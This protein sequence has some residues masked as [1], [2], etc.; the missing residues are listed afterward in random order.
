MSVLL[1]YNADQV[2]FPFAVLSKKS[3][4]E[5]LLPTSC[6]TQHQHIPFIQFRILLLCFGLHQQRHQVFGCSHQL[7]ANVVCLLDWWCTVWIAFLLT[8][9]WQVSLNQNKDV[10]HKIQNDV[11]WL[12]HK[13]T[14]QQPNSRRCRQNKLYFYHQINR[15]VW[16]M[17]LKPLISVSDK[18]PRTVKSKLLKQ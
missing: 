9:R 2:L 18:N 7:V 14:K 10:C 1:H 3:S 13:K 6:L 16:V 5:I 17:A 15:Y 12:W 4:G 8:S 11:Q